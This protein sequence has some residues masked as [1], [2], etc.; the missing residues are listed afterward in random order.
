MSCR[1][2]RLES[3]QRPLPSQSS[4]LPLS[5]ERLEEP[6]AGVEPAPR[7]YK[8]RVLA[9]DTTEAKRDTRS[10]QTK[11]H[12]TAT[13]GTATRVFAAGHDA[14]VVR[15]RAVDGDGL[16]SASGA[17]GIR[18]KGSNPD[19]HVQSVASCRLDDP[20]MHLDHERCCL[21]HS[22]SLRPWIDR[23][24]YVEGF[25][26]RRSRVGRKRAS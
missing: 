23:S 9:V 13:R 25:G 11:D 6:P 19:L 18:T 5:Y 15:P 16:P 14:K 4:A 10:G 12:E 26:A 3:N 7:P 2:A 20:G 24:S 21:C 1:H 22:P 17:G 8:G